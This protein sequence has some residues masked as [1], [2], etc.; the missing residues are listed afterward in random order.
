MGNNKNPYYNQS[1]YPD[2]T[3]YHG[4]KP[5]IK[6]EDALEHKVRRLIK[7]LKHDI[8]ESGF[9]LIARIEIRD[10]QTGRCFR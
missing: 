6:E 1:G 4:M 7:E 5:A 10:K 9:E 3:A 8:N 2:P